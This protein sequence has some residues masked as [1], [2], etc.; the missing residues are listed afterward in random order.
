MSRILKSAAA[1]AAAAAAPAAAFHGRS[2]NPHKMFVSS[3]YS[4]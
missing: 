2:K 1:A 4:E 3:F